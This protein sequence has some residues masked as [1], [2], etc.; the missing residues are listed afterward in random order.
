MRNPILGFVWYVTEEMDEM[1]G[2]ACQRKQEVL[3][4]L[5][6]PVVKGSCYG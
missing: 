2:I 6:N 1:N 5:I 3:Y 4:L